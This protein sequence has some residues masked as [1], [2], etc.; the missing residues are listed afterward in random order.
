MTTPLLQFVARFD[1]VGE[2]IGFGDE[3]YKES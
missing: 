2:I 1:G 3:G